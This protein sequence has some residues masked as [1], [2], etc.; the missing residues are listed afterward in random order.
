MISVQEILNAIA[1]FWELIVYLILN[2]R[3]ADF[4]DIAVVAFLI[5]KCIGFFRQNRGGQRA[6][7]IL[8]ILAVAGIA[9]LFDMAS[10]NW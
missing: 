10:V 7:G 3:L 5:Y 1:S 4:L 6:K 9:A 8:I 2:F